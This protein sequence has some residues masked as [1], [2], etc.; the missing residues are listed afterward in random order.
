LH[1]TRADLRE[2]GYSPSTRLLE[3]AACGTPI[4]ADEWDGIGEVLEPGKEI[5]L[6]HSA[7]DVTRHLESVSDAQAQRMAAAARER[8]CAEG[9]SVLRAEELMNYLNAA[10]GSSISARPVA[11]S[12][13]TIAAS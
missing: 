1:L 3:A 6:A 5:L 7:E 9:S 2:V 13:L 8:I 11:V 4:I 12:E 10:R